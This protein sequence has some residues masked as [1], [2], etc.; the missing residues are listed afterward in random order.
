MLQSETARRETSRLWMPDGDTSYHI[1]MQPYDGLSYY[2]KKQFPWSVDS[3]INI[4]D[5]QEE[6]AS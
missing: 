5:K 1:A 6:D 2:C 3:F 4:D